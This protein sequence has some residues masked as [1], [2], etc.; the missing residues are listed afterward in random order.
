MQINV[1]V[2]SSWAHFKSADTKVER[3]ILQKATRR[4]LKYIFD[5]IVQ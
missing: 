1:K 5:S 3:T 4:Q 2:N